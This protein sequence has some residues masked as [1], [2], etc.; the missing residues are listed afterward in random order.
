ATCALCDTT[1][2]M[3]TFAATSSAM[4]PAGCCFQR[5]RARITVAVVDAALTAV[6]ATGFRAAG[7][8]SG[9][10]STPAPDRTAAVVVYTSRPFK[11]MYVDAS[12]ENAFACALGAVTASSA[13]DTCGA[14]VTTRT[15]ASTTRVTPLRTPRHNAE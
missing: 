13:A 5:R 3:P 8:T 7:P 9:L 1:T 11:A 2:A 4:A 10:L 14:P 6:N 12:T 15:I